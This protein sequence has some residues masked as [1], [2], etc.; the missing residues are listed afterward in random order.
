VY[1][2][3]RRQYAETLHVG[4]CAQ[5]K[6]KAGEPLRLG[7]QKARA[8]RLAARRFIKDLWAE[9]RRIHGEEVGDHA[10]E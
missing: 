4:D 7:H 3:A 5:C 2:D 8:V 10:A 9:A 6:A 1:D